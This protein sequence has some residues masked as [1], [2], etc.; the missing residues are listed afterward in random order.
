MST[1]KSGWAEQ[2]G[3][4]QAGDVLVSVDGREC[5]G[6]NLRAVTNLLQGP[7]GSAFSLVI[8][9]NGANVCVEGQRVKA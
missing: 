7:V 2:S 5:A 6:L 8:E 3:D 9:R 1:I 4:V